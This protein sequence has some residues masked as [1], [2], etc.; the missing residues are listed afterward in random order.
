MKTHPSLWRSGPPIRPGDIDH[1]FTASLNRRLARH[2]L[3]Q[4]IRDA[5]IPALLLLGAMAFGWFA[6]SIFNN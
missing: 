6:H 5:A 3:A 2:R 4:S 1:D